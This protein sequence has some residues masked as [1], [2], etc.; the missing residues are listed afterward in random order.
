MIN[1]NDWAERK[2]FNLAHEL[3]HMVMDVG[4][5]LNAEKV[6]HRFA[7]SFLMPAEALWSEVGKH[8]TSISLAEIC[9]L[10]ELVGSSFQA[11]TYRCKDL[12]IIG[13]S[14]FRELFELY[15]Q[16]GWRDPPYK[17]FGAIPPEREKPKRFERLCFRAIS[18]G[19]ISEGKAAELLGISVRTLNHR[20]ENPGLT[21]V[22]EQ[23]GA[24]GIVQT[25]TTSG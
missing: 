21:E 5:A 15:K 3:G 10:K 1:K 25:T 24:E 14:L 13:V 8:R 17:E 11:I 6:A 22:A 12:G 20:L 18:E 9:R 7:G 2:R 16:K 19:A 23:E 4:P